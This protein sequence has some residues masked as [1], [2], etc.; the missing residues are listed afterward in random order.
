MTAANALAPLTFHLWQTTS[1]TASYAAS[2]SWELPE[3]QGDKADMI[4]AMQQNQDILREHAPKNDVDFS[5]L[6]KQ[7][8]S[9]ESLGSDSC[10]QPQANHLTTI[11]SYLISLPLLHIAG[12]GKKNQISGL[13][14]SCVC[15]LKALR[16]PQIHRCLYR[17]H[18]SSV[19]R[20]KAPW[21]EGSSHSLSSV[22]QMPP[23]LSGQ[24]RAHLLISSERCGS[25]P[26]PSSGEVLFLFQC[27]RGW[28]P[29]GE[30]GN[31]KE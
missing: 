5:H 10:N 26:H 11:S 29:E 20:E 1:S 16:K 6:P 12:L 28:E 19:T 14:E 30:D 23:G 17:T 18:V 24:L 21:L 9:T 7:V 4:F 2:G 3:L 27:L 13:Q 8:M 15:H 31:R 25:W 22:S